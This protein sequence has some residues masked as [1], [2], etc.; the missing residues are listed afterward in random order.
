VRVTDGAGPE[1]VDIA[2]TGFDRPVKV[3]APAY[4]MLPGFATV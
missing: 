4:R 1:S 3:T 2:L